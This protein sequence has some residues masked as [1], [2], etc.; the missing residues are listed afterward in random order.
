MKQKLIALTRNIFTVGIIAVLVLGILAAILYLIAFIAGGTLAEKIV[1]FV[2]H[3]AFP[4]MFV[5]NIL[6]CASGI[7]YTY[8]TGDRGFRFDIGKK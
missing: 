6:F 5:L 4:V 7:L 8:L 2:N 1:A 3:R